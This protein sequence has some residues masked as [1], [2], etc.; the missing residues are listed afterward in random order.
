MG[1]AEVLQRDRPAIGNHLY[2]AFGHNLPTSDGRQL[3]LVALT[4][5]HW[6]SLL[7]ITGTADV[8]SKIEN[9]TR[10]DLFSDAG[11]Y[12]ARGDIASALSKWSQTKT[13]TEIGNL[14]DAAK[15]LWGPYQSFQ[16]MV[17]SDPRASLENPMFEEIEQTGIGRMRVSGSPLNFVGRDR[18]TI[19]PASV[20]GAD[21]SAVIDDLESGVNHSD[22]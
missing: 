11:R 20:V 18:Q 17:Q 9:R 21:T 15:I 3:M 22:D 5:R 8:M 10:L 14:F 19:R 2:G 16:Q 7:E 1:E 13:L 6:K 12:E 4:N